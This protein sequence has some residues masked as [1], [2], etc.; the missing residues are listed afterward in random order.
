LNFGEGKTHIQVKRL[1]LSLTNTHHQAIFKPIASKTLCFQWSTVV[2]KYSETPVWA[3]IVDY[4]TVP[5]KKVSGK[6]IC[7]EHFEN[8]WVYMLELI[9]DEY[10][11]FIRRTAQHWLELN[12]EEFSNS[13]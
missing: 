6:E 5:S 3:S 1:Q 7:K 9:I 13:T 10:L 11:S 8:W 12:K 2:L 4:N